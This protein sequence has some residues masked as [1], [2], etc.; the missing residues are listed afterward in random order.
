MTYS[1]SGLTVRSVRVSVS[2]GAAVFILCKEFLGEME[3][4]YCS[5]SPRVEA[6]LSYVEGS[7]L[8]TV[9]SL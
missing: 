7:V 6:E 2:F 8:V 5:R 1:H 9:G 4:V 3:V